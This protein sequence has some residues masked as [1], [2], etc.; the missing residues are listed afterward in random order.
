MRYFEKFPEFREKT[1][2]THAMRRLGKA[3]EVAQPVIW[4][5]SE[6]ASFV[7]GATIHCDG[8]VGVNSHLV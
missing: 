2:G 1:V 3:E 8:G 6:R 5:A 4:L 7:T